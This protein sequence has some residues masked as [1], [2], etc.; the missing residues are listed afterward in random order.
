MDVVAISKEAV[1]RRFQTYSSTAE[2]DEVYE[3]AFSEDPKIRTM[4]L[5]LEAVTGKKI[6]VASIEDIKP[7]PGQEPVVI[8]GMEQQPRA[9]DEEQPPKAEW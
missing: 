2:I 4:R 5:I 9:P 7:S 3:E 6:R 8:Q 1:A